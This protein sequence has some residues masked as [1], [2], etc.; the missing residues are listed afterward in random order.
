VVLHLVEQAKDLGADQLF[1][2]G[3]QPLQWEWHQAA[4]H[5]PD[6]LAVLF[7]HMRC[8]NHLPLR[9]DEGDTL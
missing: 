3:K 8:G 9:I 1:V 6:E 4:I 5:T 7:G 2:F